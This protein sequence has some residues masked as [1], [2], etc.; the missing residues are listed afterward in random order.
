MNVTIALKKWLIGN[1]AG[2]DKDTSDDDHRKAAGEALIDGSLSPAKF[3]ELTVDEKDAK[4]NELSEKLDGIVGALGKLAEAQSKPADEPDAKD[5]DKGGDKDKDAEPNKNKDAPKLPEDFQ[6]EIGNIGTSQGSQDDAGN[7]PPRVK[8]VAEMYSTTKS[9]L[10][11]PE[12]NKAGR[13]CAKA[14]MPVTD[15]TD[16]RAMDSPSDLDKAV[17]GAYAKFICKVAQRG[18][19]RTFGYQGLSDHERDLLQHALRRYKWGGATRDDDF[20]DIDNRCLTPIEQKDLID[21]AGPGGSGGIEAAPIVLDDDVISTP[22]LYGELYPL[23]HTVTLDRG[24]RVEGVSIGQVG[25]GCGGVDAAAITLFNTAAYVAAFNTTIYRWEGAIRIGLDFLSDSP[26]NFG[27][28]VTQQY[29][30]ALLKALDDVIATGNG[31][32]Q[33]E[34]VMNHAGVTAVAFG[35][36]APT[37]GAY[38]TLRFTVPKEE[39]DASVKNS[40]VFCGTELS[41]QRSRAIPVGAADVRRIFGLSYDDYMWMSR[42]FKINESLTNAQQFY[43]VLARY[44]MYQRRGLTMRSSTEGDTLIRRNELLLVA[45]ARYGGQMERAAAAALTTTALA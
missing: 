43:A 9:A 35:G 10:V 5:K 15:F 8:S 24:R 38:E 30:N 44:R 11:H 17:I 19:S 42:P 12:Y 14:G 41:Y 6:K 13:R 39:H 18:S 4:A 40:I 29:G 32:T 20:A 23:V 28:I 2:V 27:Q 34:G 16:G 7:A 31:T 1:A 25:D 21:D 36:V 22:L 33:P 26:I 37:L 3:A 45:T